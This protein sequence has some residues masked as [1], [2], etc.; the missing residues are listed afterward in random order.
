MSQP[1]SCNDAHNILEQGIS[2]SVLEDETDRVVFIW[3]SLVL[4]VQFGPQSSVFCEAGVSSIHGTLL[5]EHGSTYQS[6]MEA[7]MVKLRS[8]RSSTLLF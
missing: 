8:M 3:T 5:L 6:S 2:R 4:Q 1:T 7:K